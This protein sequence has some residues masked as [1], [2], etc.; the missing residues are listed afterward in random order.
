MTAALDES[1]ANFTQTLKEEV[2]YPLCASNVRLWFMVFVTLSLR[3]RA[4]ETP[5]RLFLVVVLSSTSKCDLL[6]KKKKEIFEQCLNCRAGV[7]RQ[8]GIPLHVG[9]R[10]TYGRGRIVQLAAEG[11]EGH[12]VGGRDSLLHHLLRAWVAS[13]QPRNYLAR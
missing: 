11:Q 9:Q 3:M 1:I 6:K 7:V 12:T 4:I 8:H 5:A 13:K 2:R 10:W